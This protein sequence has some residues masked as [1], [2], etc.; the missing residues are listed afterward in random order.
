MNMVRGCGVFR[1]A[2]GGLLASTLLAWS[3]AQA[4]PQAVAQAEG[5]QWIDLQGGRMRAAVFRPS[6]P[7]PFPVLVAFHGGGGFGQRFLDWAGK[8][9]GFGYVVLVGCWLGPHPDFPP[10]VVTCSLPPFGTPGLQATITAVVLVDAAPRAPRGVERGPWGG[11]GAAL[12]WPRQGERPPRA[13]GPGRWSPCRM[14]CGK[15]FREPIRA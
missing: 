8:F 3:V 11:E 13:W 12:G 1:Q 14:S 10:P 4:A 9:A 15:A 6:G 5:P 2:A 7:G